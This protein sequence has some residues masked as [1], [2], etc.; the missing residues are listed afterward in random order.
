LASH[1]LAVQAQG[2]PETVHTMPPEA[3]NIVTAIALNEGIVRSDRDPQRRAIALTWLFHLIGDIHQPLHTVS[4]FTREY[5]DGDRGGTRM[6]VRVAADR[7]AL[8]LHRLWDGLITSTIAA[9]L[10]SRF[11]SSSFREL[12]HT[13]PESWAKES[14]EIATK[15]AYQ[16]GSERGTPKGHAQDCRDVSAVMYLFR[17]YPATSR[18]IADRRM[19]LAGYR[20]ADLLRTIDRLPPR[21]NLRLGARVKIL[22]PSPQQPELRVVAADDQ[23]E[24]DATDRVEFVVK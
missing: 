2:E 24:L 13:E 22:S 3:Q 10:I 18:L 20:L 11:S 16:N 12:D 8:E 6:C 4:L 21:A 19:Y 23:T 9:T 15:I 5:P 1:Q 17:R 14:Y 7:P